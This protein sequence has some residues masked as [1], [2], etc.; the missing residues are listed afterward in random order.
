M[1]PRYEHFPEAT[2][3]YLC[4]TNQGNALLQEVDAAHLKNDDS[5]N[6][7]VAEIK[8]NGD[9]ST[10]EPYTPES[11]AQGFLFMGIKARLKIYCE[12]QGIAMADLYA[13]AVTTG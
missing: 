5:F 9:I 12:G 3:A 7:V 8:E 2:L 6:A 11:H 4:A 13:S 1:S 10:P